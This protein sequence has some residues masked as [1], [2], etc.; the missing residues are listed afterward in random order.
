MIVRN[1][2]GSSCGCSGNC[3]C[4]GNCG[5][6]DFSLSLNPDSVLNTPILGFPAWLVGLGVVAALFLFTPLTASEKRRG[7]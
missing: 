1:G 3:G 6:G 4:K 7:R 5:I 2:L